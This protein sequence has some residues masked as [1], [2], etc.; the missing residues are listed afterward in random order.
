MIAISR[1][2]L[3]GVV[4]DMD[5]TLTVPNL[6]FSDL[7]ARCNVS[8][9]QD[10]LRAIAEM[11]DPEQASKAKA[12]VEEVEK[13]G[14]RTLCLMP[15]AKEL[16]TWLKAHQL[17]IALVTRNSQTTVDHFV[18]NLW[19]NN[20]KQNGNDG[21][22]GDEHVDGDALNLD[23]SLTI[24]REENS[25][26]N[27]NFPPKPDPSAMYHIAQQWN[28]D[29][30]TRDLL[31]VGDSP[32]N[33]IAFGNAAGI[34]TA[35][36]DIG[37]AKKN[38]TSSKSTK[39]PD[40]ENVNE[41]MQADL[42]VGCLWELPHLLWQHFHI[43]GPLGTS[44]PLL[45][46]PAPQ[47]L[48]PAAKAAFEGDIVTLISLSAQEQHAPD[49]TGNTPLVWAS[50]AGHV[51]IVKLLLLNES[52]NGNINIRGY[53]GATAVCRASRRGHVQVLKLLLEHNKNAKSN[54][55]VV[56]ADPNVPNIKMQYPLHFAAFKRNKQAVSILL[57]YGANTMVMDRKGRTP[58]EDTSDTSIREM[59]VEVRNEQAAIFYE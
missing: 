17:P 46:Y 45:K 39:D 15:G 28:I 42:C 18:Q 49:D 21:E 43:D 34:S 51:E 1:P 9:G 13:E 40:H 7:Y 48:T 12:I 5:G 11:K 32:A 54:T 19:K 58:A 10:I 44:Q 6:D 8:L 4:F 56:R 20:K 3:R 47:P 2:K 22:D 16:G 53:L 38:G 24:S 55:S 52:G 26:N 31:M 57:D 50:D 27:N 30:P 36:L 25:S 23:F 59:I 33:D 35:L 29:L 14:R 41:K 37:T